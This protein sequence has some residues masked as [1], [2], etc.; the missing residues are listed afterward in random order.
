MAKIEVR[1]DRLHRNYL[2][3][4]ENGKHQAYADSIKDRLKKEMDEKKEA[5]RAEDIVRGVFV[6][7]GMM[8]KLEPQSAQRGA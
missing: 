8:P 1:R 7:G 3:R 2:R 5:I 4:K 6:P